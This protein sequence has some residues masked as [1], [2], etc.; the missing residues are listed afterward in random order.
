MNI[1]I[2]LNRLLPFV[3]L[4]NVNAMQA[5]DNKNLDARHQSIVQPFPH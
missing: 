3:L 1:R 5:Q 4:I 2:F